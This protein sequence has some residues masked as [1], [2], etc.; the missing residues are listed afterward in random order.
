MI[1]LD[2]MRMTTLRLVFPVWWMLSIIRQ[3]LKYAVC[4]RRS[5]QTADVKYVCWGENEQ[6]GVDFENLNLTLL[7]GNC[8]GNLHNLPKSK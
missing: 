2:L 3:L 6:F 7:T 4:L 5:V 8:V 1:I